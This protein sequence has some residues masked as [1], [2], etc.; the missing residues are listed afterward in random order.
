MRALIVE[1]SKDLAHIISESLEE[2]GIAAD[3]V[4]TAQAGISSADQNKPDVVIMELL[5][6]DHNGLEFI[7]EF[8]SYQDWF[9]VPII[10]YSDLSAEELGVAVGW[11]EDMNIQRHFYKPTTT[12]RELKDFIKNM[13]DEN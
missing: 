1:P 11:K 9:D 4:H 2:D 3:I 8:K 13:P 10:I 12:L 6:S 5:I 7:H